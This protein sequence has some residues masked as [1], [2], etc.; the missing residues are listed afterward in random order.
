MAAVTLCVSSASAL[1]VV[2]GAVPYAISARIGEE[3]DRQEREYFGLFPGFGEFVEARTYKTPTEQ[4]VVVAQ[5]QSLGAAGDTTI[6][7]DQA[8]AAHLQR[9]IER[10]EALIR[11]DAT[12]P[13]DTI[14]NLAKLPQL[15]LNSEERHA[16]II[17]ADGREVSGELLFVSRDLL[18]MWL[19]NERFCWDSTGTLLRPI[20]PTEVQQIKIE[21]GTSFW[22][23]MGGGALLG[24]ALGL[25]YM[26]KADTDDGTESDYHGSDYLVV[27]GLLG[28]I[29]FVGGALHGVWR[30]SEDRFD[31]LSDMNRYA[32]HLAAMQKSA[33]FQIAPPEFRQYIQAR[34]N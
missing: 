12:L 7:M 16:K 20:K 34:E 22:K 32:K 1:Q 29:G 28:G 30:G 18:M 15:N 25:T 4:V 2:D 26:T 23:G 27:S 33:Y 9:Y 24:I 11:Q 10:F 19:G 13:W 5:R 6:T 14:Y 31:I 3:I 17:T 21:T 8:A